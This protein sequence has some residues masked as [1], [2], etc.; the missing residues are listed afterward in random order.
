MATQG[1][2]SA[3]LEHGQRMLIGH[4]WRLLRETRGTVFI[5][6]NATGETEDKKDKNREELLGGALA[7]KPF[8][9]KFVE[10]NFPH[11]FRW[12]RKLF[13]KEPQDEISEHK[14]LPEER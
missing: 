9:A 13:T 2:T 3:A 7:L 6:S 10:I 5:E 8:D 12:A 11:I 14:Q 1:D 4:L